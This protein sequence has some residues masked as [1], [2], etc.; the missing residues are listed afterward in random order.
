MRV[1]RRLRWGLAVAG[2]AMLVAL[3]ACEPTAPPSPAISAAPAASSAPTPSSRSVAPAPAPG[4]ATPREGEAAGVR[5]LEL[6][7]GGARSADRLPMVIA[8]HGLGDTPE[9]FA[10]VL[11]DLDAPARLV[12]PR[13]LEP[14]HGGYSW[15]ALEGG[16]SSESTARGIRRAAAALSACIGELAATRPTAGRPVVTGFSQG[17]ALSFALAALHPRSIAAAF[18]D[19]GW[20]PPSIELERAPEPLAIVAL[21]GAADPRIPI[22]PTRDAVLRLSAS[23]YR[24]ELREFPRV[25]HTID[26]AMRRELGGLVAAAIREAAR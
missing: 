14:F 13:G 24:A 17:G 12:V 23:G 4:D 9:A 16:P 18:P 11:A 7:T 3:G 5:F 8:I 15:F 10:R 1:A 2:A 25:G 6:T 21:H 26:A 20:L 22:G 19:G